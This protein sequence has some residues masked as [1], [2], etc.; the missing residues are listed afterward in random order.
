M[1]DSIP[2][3]RRQVNS[4]Q[5]QLRELRKKQTEQS[6]VTQERIVFR[7]VPVV[8]EVLV[9]VDNPDHVATIRKLQE[10]LCR[11]TLEQGS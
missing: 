6:A 8:K 4:L 2:S 7:D 3:L 5:E 1:A 11:Y 9:Y 10:N